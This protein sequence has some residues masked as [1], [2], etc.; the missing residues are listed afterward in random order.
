VV[1]QPASTSYNT[2]Q[3][4]FGISFPNKIQ[5]GFVGVSGVPIDLPWFDLPMDFWELVAKI[6]KVGDTISSA[7]SNIGVNT[8]TQTPFL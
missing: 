6:P 1:A 5:L 3:S 2:F 4:A 7:V 8:S